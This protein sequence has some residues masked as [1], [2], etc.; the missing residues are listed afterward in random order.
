MDEIH[1]YCAACG[2][3]LLALARNAG[4]SCDCPQCL[5][6]VPIPG[7][8]ARLGDS[9]DFGG[10]FSPKIL[11]I[12]IKF[13]GDCCGKKFRVDARLQGMTLD[14]PVCYKPTKIPE[15]GGALP[16]A[17]LAESP[18]RATA[19]LVRLSPEECEF[20]SAPM[21]REGETLVRAGGQ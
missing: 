20:L 7:Y 10:L 13:F 16:P 3:K 9:A 2:G 18:A 17:E 6:V 19:S 8:R 12:E 4:G 15:W 14:C 11:A 1:F 21:N 5:R